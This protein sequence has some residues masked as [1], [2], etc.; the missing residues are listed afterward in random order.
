MSQHES[1]NVVMCS[2]IFLPMVYFSHFRIFRNLSKFTSLQSDSTLSSG[3]V[4]N[5]LSK[6]YLSVAVVQ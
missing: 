1:I 5:I 3:N 2:E 6:F 4:K